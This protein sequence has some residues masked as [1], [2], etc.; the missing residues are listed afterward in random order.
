MLH[1]K[2]ILCHESLEPNG[3]TPGVEL[4]AGPGPWAPEFGENMDSIF[5]ANFTSKKFFHSW[6]VKLTFLYIIGMF[7]LSPSDGWIF[8]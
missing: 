5:G 8:N 1:A 4:I 3:P 7:A 6:F 2:N